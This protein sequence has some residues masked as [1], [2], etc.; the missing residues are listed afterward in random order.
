[1]LLPYHPWSL[2]VDCHLHDCGM[3][4]SLRSR[5]LL[6]GTN[7]TVQCGAIVSISNTTC[8][9]TNSSS[10]SSDPECALAVSVPV[11]SYLC[12][13]T[14][15]L[16]HIASGSEEQDR[17]PC[18]SDVITYYSIFPFTSCSAWWTHHTLVH[19][20]LDPFAGFRKDSRTWNPPFR[21]SLLENP[22]PTSQLN[23]GSRRHRCSRREPSH[24]V[25]SF[26]LIPFHS[27]LRSQQTLPHLQQYFLLCSWH[28]QLMP[29]TVFPS[30]FFFYSTSSTKHHTLA[31]CSQTLSIQFRCCPPV[32]KKSSDWLVNDSVIEGWDYG[33]RWRFLLHRY[34]SLRAEGAVVALFREL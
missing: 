3:H 27:L 17:W 11:R 6:I 14:S 2:K 25:I 24:L 33:L 19:L 28:Y 4:C 5:C 21:W 9:S 10:L 16:A 34:P 20:R 12:W 30:P 13:K 18:T 22:C 31:P 23:F 15:A 7:S 8:F 32:K 29:L 26:L 1:M